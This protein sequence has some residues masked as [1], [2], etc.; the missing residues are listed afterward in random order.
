MF[1]C[2]LCSA[3]FRHGKLLT[4]H[5]AHKHSKCGYC[6]KTINDVVKHLASKHKFGYKCD[7]CDF[8]T[9]RK[10][11]MDSHIFKKHLQC[12]V[13][14]KRFT[15]GDAIRKHLS[16]AHGKVTFQC[17]FCEYFTNYKNHMD[18]HLSHVHLKWLKKNACDK[19]NYRACRPS[20]LKKH[21]DAV[22]LNLRKYQKK[23][24]KKTF[25][26][27]TCDFKSMKK[28]DVTVHKEAVHLKLRK[29][30][31]CD[32]CDYKTGY[33]HCLNRHILSKH[34]ESTAKTDYTG[35]SPVKSPKKALIKT[36][37][38]LPSPKPGKWIVRLERLSTFEQ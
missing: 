1:S 8:A 33:R 14:F 37:Q 38:T 31:K 28:L 12:F 7:N 10:M 23:G 24:L 15:S 20:T 26:C 3:V 30:F 27:D 35:S 21:N 17:S 13:C 32:C 4:S 2:D 9:L 5:L 29:K 36:Y 18:E 11:S 25:Q 6:L 22:H 19:C 16:E 34:P